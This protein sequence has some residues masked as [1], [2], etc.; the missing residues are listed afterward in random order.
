MKNLTDSAK[1]KLNR[2]LSEARASL[3]KCTSV[4]ADEIE[5]PVEQDNT[6]QR[7]FEERFE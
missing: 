2:Y 1:E 3:E 7:V 4:D 6:V 5:V